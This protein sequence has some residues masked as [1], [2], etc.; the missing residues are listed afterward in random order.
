MKINVFSKMNA[1]IVK[2]EAFSKSK[3]LYKR[4]WLSHMSNFQKW[5]SFMVFAAFLGKSRC[6]RYQKMI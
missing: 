5:Q 1:K 3:L 2:F 4:V 6:R